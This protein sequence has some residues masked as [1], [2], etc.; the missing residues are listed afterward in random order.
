MV[1][2]A[3]HNLQRLTVRIFYKKHKFFLNKNYISN[4][5][6]TLIIISTLSVNY[7]VHIDQL[8]ITIT[9]TGT[10]VGEGGTAEFTAVASGK[11]KT[12]FKYQWKKRGS[13]SLPDKVSVV[14]REVL[15]IPNVL[16]SDEG[17]YYCTVTNEWDRNMESN[18]VTLTVE[19]TYVCIAMLR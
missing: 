10:T 17:Q 2:M 15:M 14:N 9:S 8:S 12:N 19:G 13:D 11:G 4:N 1:N 16:E 6:L 7:F 18:D 5:Y 3:Y